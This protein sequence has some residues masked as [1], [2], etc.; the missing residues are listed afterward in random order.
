[1][2][3]LR[4]DV[5]RRARDVRLYRKLDAQRPA[6]FLP[7]L[8][9]SP[10]TSDSRRNPKKRRQIDHSEPAQPCNRPIPRKLRNPCQFTS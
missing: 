1:M 10:F 9:A 5:A 6:D 4:A 8:A 2:T 7:D 3:T